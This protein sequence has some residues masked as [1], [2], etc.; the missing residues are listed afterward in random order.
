MNT[1]EIARYSTL[2]RT[3][4]RFHLWCWGA[5]TAVNRATQRRSEVFLLCLGMVEVACR[6][7]LFDLDGVLID[8]TPAVARVWRR[9]AIA[10]G[11]DPKE[12]IR[13]AHGRPSLTTIRELLPESDHEAENRKVEQGEIEDFVGQ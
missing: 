5:I 2:G 13:R 6:G 4:S 12:T 7:L 8:S 10:H 3:D 1:S 11:L 9:W